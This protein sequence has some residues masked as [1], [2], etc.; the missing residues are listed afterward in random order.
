LHVLRALAALIAVVAVLGGGTAR[1]QTST[2]DLSPSATIGNAAPSAA[3]DTGEPD[4]PKSV[5]GTGP[6]TSPD[7]SPTTPATPGETTGPSESPGT[8]TSAP[9]TPT[10][11]QSPGANI[12][13][14]ATSTPGQ[15]S[16]GPQPGATV[17]PPPQLGPHDDLDAQSNRVKQKEHR[18]SCQAGSRNAGFMPRVRADLIP[19]DKGGSW[20]RFAL[21]L[22][23]LAA[24]LFG[25]ALALA[26]HASAN[27]RDPPQAK[28]LLENAGMVV[29]VCGGVAALASQFIPGIGVHTRPVP[30]A[31][32]VVRKVDAR[33]TRQDFMSAVG[34]GRTVK[35]L[36]G[37]EMGNVVWVKLHLRGYR[38]RALRLGRTSITRSS[39]TGSRRSI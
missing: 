10:P 3:A 19:Y 35:G 4:A 37:E 28:S 5:G 33:I 12:T 1:A 26:R 18:K 36:N 29:A 6:S 21:T 7:D 17:V 16:G 34:P 23:A 8:A 9:A 15:P 24:L 32:M 39:A 22:G 27:K 14:P 31:D 2:I 25:V 13:P 38:G 30:Q 11:V 20:T